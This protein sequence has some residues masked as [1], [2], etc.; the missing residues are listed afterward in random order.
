MAYK[1]YF[2]SER[3]FWLEQSTQQHGTGV[4]HGVMRLACKEQQKQHY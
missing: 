3:E 1:V 2:M 4:D